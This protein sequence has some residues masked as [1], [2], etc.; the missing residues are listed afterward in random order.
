M[1]PA[2]STPEGN[3]K[4]DIRAWMEENIP[5]AWG[6][7]PVKAVYGVGGIPDHIYSVPVEIT[8]DMVGQTV[9]LFVGIEAK[10]TGKRKTQSPNQ[11]DRE[12]DIRNA[13]GIYLLVAG[14]EEVEL[15]LSSLRYP[16]SED[17][18]PTIK[19]N[20]RF[21]AYRDA[22]NWVLVE[23]IPSKNK[24]GEAVT[25][26]KKT[27]HPDIQRM[28]EHIIDK[29]LGDCASLEEIK[30]LLVVTIKLFHKYVNSMAEGKDCG[31]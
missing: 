3:V 15:I 18:R 16:M 31:G 26:I 11:K 14:C 6:W 29:K 8:P 13:G 21:S 4:K 10:A 23:S 24:D 25:K 12:R 5:S 27:Y 1:A 7:M 22:Y 28:C 17:D 20:D 19:I 30:K 9:G 2:M